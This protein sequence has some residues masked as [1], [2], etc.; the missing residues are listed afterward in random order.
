MRGPAYLFLF[1][2]PA[3]LAASAP[4]APQRPSADAALA[5]AQSEAR[6]AAKRLEAL[7]GQAAKAKSEADRLQ[8]EQATAAAAIEEAEARISESDAKL[9]LAQAQAALAE[10]R[11][12]TRRAPLAALIAGLA[13]M[14]RQP[15][16][17]TLAD[18]GSV[19]ELVRVK[20]L[21]D[22]T[23]PVIERRSAALRSELMER[24]RLASTANAARSELVQGRQ[25]LSRR[26]RK[27]AEL[28]AKAA[29][30]AIRLAGEAFGA[31][32]RVLASGETLTTAS[33]DLA[34]R[35]LALRNAAG[36]AGLGLAPAR[37]I[38]GDAAMPAQDFAYSLPVTAALSDGLGTVSRSGIVSRGLRF[39]TPRGAAV[40]A[41]ADGKVLF[42]A[43]YRGQDGVVIIEHDN[44]WTSLLL[45]VASDRPK[46]TSVKR[47]EYLGR[48]LGPVGVELR[49]NGQPVSPALIAASSVPLSNGSENR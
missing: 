35:R 39:D 14:G 10:Q 43:P 8:A 42:A 15:P 31:G 4:V 19:D 3:L 23:M 20:A 24:R 33:S 16:L 18:R 28:E 38:R 29:D 9:R 17:L 7:E 46:G 30:R 12:A 1:A 47:G 40:I 34:E 13:T 6:A 22:A 48:A 25:E 2:I 21:L 32:D 41:P 27:F 49:R 44:G 26:Q 36:V 37:P 11:L 45:G 5:Q